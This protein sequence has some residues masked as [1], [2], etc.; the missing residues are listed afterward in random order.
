MYNYIYLY[1]NKGKNMTNHYKVN[2]SNFAN[3]NSVACNVDQF[4]AKLEGALY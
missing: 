3:L 4:H 1:T 2:D